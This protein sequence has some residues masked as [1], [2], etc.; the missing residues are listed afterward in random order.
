MQKDHN[1]HTMVSIHR[2][3]HDICRRCS[4][5]IISLHDPSPHPE[6]QLRDAAAA[7]VALGGNNCGDDEIVV[8]ADGKPTRKRKTLN[9]DEKAKQN[10]DRNR[11]HAKVDILSHPSHLLMLIK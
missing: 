1:S 8:G 7:E 9:P 2:I 4:S 5:L 11:E 3:A 10:R 6:K